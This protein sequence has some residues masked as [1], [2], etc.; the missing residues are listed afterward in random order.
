MPVN[1]QTEVVKFIGNNTSDIMIDYFSGPIAESSG[2]VQLQAYK[3][4]AAHSNREIQA[5]L[6][7]SLP[8]MPQELHYEL[9]I[10]LAKHSDKITREKFANNIVIFPEKNRKKSLEIL[11]N[12]ENRT[13][14]RHLKTK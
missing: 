12:P 2:Q 13:D 5:R 7:Y 3:I 8:R 14:K 1:L 10:T 4:I 9:L 6:Y 11:L